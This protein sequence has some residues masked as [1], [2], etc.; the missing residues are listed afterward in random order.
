M[1]IAKQLKIALYVQ[2]DGKGT[3]MEPISITNHGMADKVHPGPGRT[4][5]FGRDEFGR[6]VVKTTTNDAPGGLNTS[7]IEE[8]DCGTLSYLSKK[9]K[10]QGCFPLQERWYKCGRIDGPNWDKL[11]HY[12][13]IQLTQK[14]RGAGPTRD[15]TDAVVFDT[16]ELSWPYTVELV[17]H[18]LSALSI[19][20]DQNLND[21][22]VL[23]DLPVGCDDCF[24]GYT[25]D[26]IMYIAASARAASPAD[27]A[28]L[29][30][31]ITGG[32]SFLPVLA[33]PFAAGEDILFVALMF[34]TDTTFR[35]IVVNGETTAQVKYAD[36]TLGA[37][38][39]ASWSG[40]VTV[41]AAAVNAFEW[42]FY[43]RAYIS[44]AGDI[45][46]ST[47]QGESFAAATFTGSNNINA[48]A[49][50][51][52]GD[53]VWAVGAANTI[54]LEN[55]QSGTFEVKTGPLGGG[56]F[57]SVF[58]ANDG[59]LY[60][61]NGQSLYLSVNKAENAGGWTELKDFGTNKVVK[62]I[63]CP[64]GTQAL[65]GDSQL[66]R[67]VVDDTA[68]G[69]GQ[70]WESED[71]GNSFRMVT[72]LTNTGYNAAVFSPNDDNLAFIVGDGGVVQK[73]AAKV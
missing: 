59:R 13:E 20:E 56:V 10:L 21:I 57:Y 52:A 44:N 65:G 6:Y 47:D 15:A 39:V 17:K 45:Y 29:W 70:V 43:N 58:E 27:K 7:T 35:V 16:Y 18:Q 30:Y 66:I 14:T 50:N 41:G 38:G 34:L 32:S 61:G 28:E 2:P 40:A 64:G 8:D 48:F 26:E 68:G 71:G 46:I 42:L 72:T 33:D 23:S 25:P 69:T 54:L 12:G 22:A 60:A 55:N 67:V 9:F 53:R 63:N 11:L 5:I 1:T 51:N 19:S 37:E 3:V 36:I 62:V 73:F 4:P 24:P 31:S 49:R